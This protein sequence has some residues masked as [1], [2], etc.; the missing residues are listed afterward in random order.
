MSGGTLE[1]EG[2]CPIC[3]LD[4]TFVATGSWLRDNLWCQKCEGGSIP[5]ERALALVLERELPDWRNLSIHESSPISRGLSAKLIKCAPRYVGSQLF[6]SGIRGELVNGWRNEDIEC[7]TFPDR[8]FDLVITQDVTEHVF[9]P[10]RMFQDIFRTLR[11]GGIYLST[12]PI[13]KS[14]VGPMVQLAGMSGDGEIT[15]FRDPPEYHGN[16]I[17]SDGS[18]VTWEYGY[19]IHQKVAEWVPFQVEISRFCDAHHGIL[20]EFTEVLLCRKTR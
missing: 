7:A 6:P 12:F 5:R 14:S 10:A 16:P 9:N 8:T 11:P 1:L 19:D 18:L 20:G 13:H 17:D 15:Y 2:F 3:Q 4:T